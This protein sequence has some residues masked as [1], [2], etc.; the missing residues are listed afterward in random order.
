MRTVFLAMAIVVRLVDA[1][2]SLQ[3]KGKTSSRVRKLPCSILGGSV[4]RCRQLHGVSRDTHPRPDM[5]RSF[6]HSWDKNFNQIRTN[7]VQNP[8]QTHISIIPVTVDI[9]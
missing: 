2:R 3:E 8:Y 5:F 9:R 6:R 4:A 1:G 7:L